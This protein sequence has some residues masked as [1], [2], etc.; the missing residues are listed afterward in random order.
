MK[1]KLLFAAGI[2]T[3]GAAVILNI[4]SCSVIG[5]GIGAMA[6]SSQPDKNSIDF[7]QL[8]TMTPSFP[9]VIIMRDSN[10]I[11]GKYLGTEMIPVSEYAEAYSQTRETMKAIHY[12]PALGDSFDLPSKE[13]V[14]FFGFDRDR[15]LFKDKRGTIRGGSIANIDSLVDCGGNITDFKI[16]NKLIEEGKIPL[17][18]A[19]N[20]MDATETK[21]IR[22]D[23]IE[24]I[25]IMAKK[26]G[27]LTGFLIGAVIDLLMIFSIRSAFEGFN[28]G[29]KL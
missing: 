9:V 10:Q 11:N 27:R 23:N 26:Q 3:I 29:L 22:L 14:S 28:P 21:R 18:T 5:Y 12:L 24:E 19:I 16:V 25:Q 4:H 2:L 17:V 6:D 1:S 8:K 7:A 20:I 15:I 13:K